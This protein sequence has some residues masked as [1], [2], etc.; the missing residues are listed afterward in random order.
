MLRLVKRQ[1]GSLQNLSL[2]LQK[3]R[4]HKNRVLELVFTD[5][6]GTTGF[7]LDKKTMVFASQMVLDQCKRHFSI[8]HEDL[9]IKRT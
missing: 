1:K 2:S 8:V 6:K 3:L 4:N 7:S 9:T 5:I